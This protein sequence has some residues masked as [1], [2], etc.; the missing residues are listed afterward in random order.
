MTKEA[1]DGFK[2]EAGLSEEDDLTGDDP[3]LGG[4]G[5]AGALVGETERKVLTGLLDLK[6][7]VLEGLL[8]TW[9]L[10]NCWELIC[11]LDLTGLTDLMW[12]VLTG[13]CLVGLGALGAGFDTSL[14]S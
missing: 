12:S 9:G 6:S 3:D 5:G 8:D 11:W 14:G 13:A 7:L 10:M 2:G 4:G 1:S